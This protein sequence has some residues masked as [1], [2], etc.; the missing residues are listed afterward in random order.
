MSEQQNPIQEMKPQRRQEGVRLENRFRADAC[1][2]GRQTVR[3]GR[4][5]QGRD[6]ELQQM[7]IPF[8]RTEKKARFSLADVP[9]VFFRFVRAATVRVMVF[10]T[11]RRFDRR[12]RIALPRNGVCMV[13]TA[14]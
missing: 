1:D 11:V 8:G 4:D 2:Y 13:Q 6:V 9:L 14:A 7:P 3:K 12:R 10:V 5:R